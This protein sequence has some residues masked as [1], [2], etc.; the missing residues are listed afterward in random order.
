MK[1]E[2]CGKSGL[3]TSSASQLQ[4][5]TLAAPSWALHQFL[6]QSE[7]HTHQPK[8]SEKLV[9]TPNFTSLN[10][11]IFDAPTWASPVSFAWSVVSASASEVQVPRSE[12]RSTPVVSCQEARNQA[13]NHASLQALM[14]PN[15][16]ASPNL[17]SSNLRACMGG[18][19]CIGLAG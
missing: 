5:L 1:P 14:A 17:Q 15:G 9:K 19:G 2:T 4:F 7:W 12:G 8:I 13:A 3:W 11:T 18:C 10:L 16:H 6:T